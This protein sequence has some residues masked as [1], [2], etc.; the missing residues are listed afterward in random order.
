MTAPSTVLQL[1]E[2][3]D[4]G[5]A[6]VQRLA[7]DRGIRVLFIKGPSL[8]RQG[9]RPARVSGDVDVLVDPERFAEFCTAV[10]DSGWT[11][12][13]GNLISTLT[14]L[15]SMTFVRKDW[16]CDI[17]AHSF[18]PGFLA[19]P[20]TVFAHLWER[21]TSMPFAHVPCAAADRVAGVLILAL[22][23]LRS[24]AT[25]SRHADELA[26]LRALA[27]TEQ[28]R[29]DA[30]AL[31]LATGSAST[32]ETVW[33]LLGVE[34]A[35]PPSERDSEELRAWRERVDSGSHGAYFWFVALRKAGWRRRVAIL[36]RAL[37]PTRHD[38]LVTRPEVVDTFAGRTRGRLQRF[39][40]GIR[41]LPR[42]IRTLVRHRR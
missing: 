10:L 17:D 33:P 3:V 41:S 13:D 12:R 7:D 42:A 25:Q 4:L 22:H 31:A 29:M 18:F 1:S 9:L 30:A 24:T 21:R 37:W 27:L 20:A 34:V 11:E 15:H 26:Q 36:G 32:L 2:A 16:P 39:G 19:P 38:L 5:H 6:W 23:S 14:T 40:R 8:H 35:P 28:E